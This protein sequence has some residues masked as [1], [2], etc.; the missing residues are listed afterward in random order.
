MTDLTGESRH[1]TEGDLIQ[2]RPCSVRIL[3]VTPT[4]AYGHCVTCADLHIIDRR[5]Y[6]EG[7]GPWRPADQSGR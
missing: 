1:L 2:S 7:S 4:N 5:R 3:K 6:E